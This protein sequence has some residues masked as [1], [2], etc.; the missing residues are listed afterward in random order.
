MNHVSNLLCPE[1]EMHHNS[2]R[3]GLDAKFRND[4]YARLKL[5]NCVRSVYSKPQFS[6]EMTLL[7]SLNAGVLRQQNI[8]IRFI[9]SMCFS[10]LDNHALG[11]PL[12]YLCIYRSFLSDFTVQWTLSLSLLGQLAS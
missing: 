2:R 3:K 7:G 5:D 10:S 4:Y 1:C 8:I 9:C 12:S 11:A 6:K